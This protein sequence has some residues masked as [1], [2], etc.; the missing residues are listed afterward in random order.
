MGFVGSGGSAPGNVRDKKSL[1]G[2]GEI[3]PM[4]LTDDRTHYGLISIFNHWLI[5]AL[6]IG[7]LAF[8]L[9]MADL[10]RSPDKQQLVNIHKSIGIFIL[11]YG[12][13]R[14]LWRVW[15][16]FPE[17]ASVMPHWQAT[18]AKAVH[19]LLLAGILLMPVSG[20]IMSSSGG[21]AVSFFGLFSLPP[22]GESEIVN[23][24]AANVHEWLGYFLIA[25][26]AVHLAGALKHHVIDKDATLKRM[27]GR[28]S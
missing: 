7:M 26:I 28:E 6:M 8:G 19:Y 13:W 12:V 3:A 22:L 15:Q 1:G 27:L 25:V 18:S 4:K 24:A 9:Y 20:Y 23:R 2:E 21:H 14:I 11:F 5:M 16:R 17:E 10:P